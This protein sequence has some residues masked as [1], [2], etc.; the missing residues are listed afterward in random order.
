[1]SL[2]NEKNQFLCFFNTH[3]ALLPLIIDLMGRKSSVGYRVCLR[4]QTQMKKGWVVGFV[5]IGM[6]SPSDNSC[7]RIKRSR[8][9]GNLVFFSSQ[10]VGYPIFPTIRYYFQCF[11]F[12]F[13]RCPFYVINRSAQFQESEIIEE[14]QPL[15]LS[16]KSLKFTK[17]VLEQRFVAL[18]C[19]LLVVSFNTYDGW[20]LGDLGQGSVPNYVIKVISK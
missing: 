20:C 13:L 5:Y 15:L 7:N 12:S 4:E 3:F 19:K 17:S 10:L 6:R 8:S 11:L 9:N 2:G 1:M 16:R 18:Q 14:A